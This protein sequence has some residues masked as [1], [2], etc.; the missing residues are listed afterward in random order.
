LSHQSPDL[1]VAELAD[2][3]L[4][5]LEHARR[6]A[7]T[8]RAYRSELARLTAFHDGDVGELDVATLRALLATRASL[9]AASRARTHTAIGSFLG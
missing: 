2:A 3:Y 9:S 1:D 4:G 8:L 5:A 6:S 7:R